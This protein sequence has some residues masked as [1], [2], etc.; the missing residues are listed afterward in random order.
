MTSSWF[1]GQD[2]G[3]SSRPAFPVLPGLSF[4]GASFS[5]CASFKGFF[6]LLFMPPFPTGPF[7]HLSAPPA[8]QKTST[9]VR[10]LP[11]YP[12]TV[13]TF[14]A[15]GKKAGNYVLKCNTGRTSS[16]NSR[17][18]VIRDSVMSFFTNPGF[19]WFFFYLVSMFLRLEFHFG[20]GLF[21]WI[22]GSLRRLEIR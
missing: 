19:R 12:S 8:I 17:F 16:S 13:Y 4:S 15:S 22:L 1:F 21:Y 7:S 2:A 3:A 9:S 18:L 10:Y 14:D 5:F 11:P 20:R 6:F